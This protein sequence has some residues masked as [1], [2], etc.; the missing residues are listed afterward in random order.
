MVVK[1]TQSLRA[2]ILKLMKGTRANISE[3]GDELETIIEIIKKLTHHLVR[4]EKSYEC[5]HHKVF[6]VFAE[7]INRNNEIQKIFY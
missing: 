3:A 4:K 1:R 7:L 2:E 5:L 6:R